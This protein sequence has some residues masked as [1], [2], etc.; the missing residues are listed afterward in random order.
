MPS[1]WLRTSR[2]N[3]LRLR[4]GFFLD[5]LVFSTSICPT[6]KHKRTRDRRTI[7]MLDNMY[8]YWKNYYMRTGKVSAAPSTSKHIHV[9]PYLFNIGCCNTSS[10]QALRWLRV[11]RTARATTAI[12][13]RRVVLLIFIYVT[14]CCGCFLPLPARKQRELIGITLFD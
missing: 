9:H 11:N 6:E 1:T 5:A 8:T 7:E 13:I 10:R 14:I 3:C 4:F 2:E 12:I